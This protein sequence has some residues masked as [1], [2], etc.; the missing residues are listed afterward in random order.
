MHVI[1]PMSYQTDSFPHYQQN[2]YHDHH[3]NSSDDG[4]NQPIPLFLLT[5]V[6]LQFVVMIP[7]V[8]VKTRGFSFATQVSREV[9]GWLRWTYTYKIFV[10][11]YLCNVSV[12]S[13]VKVKTYRNLPAKSRAHD[14]AQP[15]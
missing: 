9:F 10:I 11:L 12:A 15:Q 13:K 14:T 5:G 1:S 2:Q 8:R 7:G 3:D 4:A 6:S